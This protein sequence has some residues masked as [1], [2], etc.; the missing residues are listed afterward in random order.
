MGGILGDLNGGLHLRAGGQLARLHSPQI[1]RLR[2]LRD[3]GAGLL[4]LIRHNL[5]TH[6]SPSLS[7]SE[8]GLK[9]T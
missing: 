5:S 3:L 6:L 2:Q 4:D 7:Q 8:Q 1:G 9:R